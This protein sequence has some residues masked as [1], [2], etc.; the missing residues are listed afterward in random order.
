MEKA[1][2]QILTWT[3]EISE[4]KTPTWDRLPQIPLYL[5]QVVGFLESELEGL[6]SDENEKTITPSMINNYV[7]KRVIPPP[8]KKKYDAGHLAR[9][10][11]IYTIKQILPINQISKYLN[12]FVSEENTKEVLEEYCHKQ[13]QALCCVARRLSEKLESAAEDQLEELLRGLVLDFILQANA[14]RM[15]AEC[16]I[17]ALPEESKDK[18]KRS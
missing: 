4:Y 13:D 16:I 8:V 10:L 17:G 15:A 3:S 12:H 2:E 18:K 1:K 6:L 14:M 5:D 11:A 9:L 7:K